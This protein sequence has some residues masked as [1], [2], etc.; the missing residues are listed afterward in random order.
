MPAVPNKGMEVSLDSQKTAD[1][2]AKE[3]QVMAEMG[4]KT[5]VDVPLDTEEMLE[6]DPTKEIVVKI[7]KKEI[8]MT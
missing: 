3:K 2:E 4:V 7:D 5:R 8:F 6:Y 1:Y